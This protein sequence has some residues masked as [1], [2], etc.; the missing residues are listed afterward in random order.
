MP[1]LKRNSTYKNNNNRK[2]NNN[3]RSRKLHRGIGSRH[4][5]VPRHVKFSTIHKKIFPNTY[6]NVEYRE[7]VNKS[8]LQKNNPDYPYN[9]EIFDKLRTKKNI[10]NYRGKII[11]NLKN[12]GKTL[13]NN[14]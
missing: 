13:P 7:P 12:K 5:P 1:S 14:T 10:N 9:N 4:L 11:K 2:N 6:E 3:N 8:T